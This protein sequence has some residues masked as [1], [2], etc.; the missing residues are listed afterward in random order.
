MVANQKM[1]NCEQVWQ[2]ISNYIDGDVDAA[3]RASMDEHFGTCKRCA[4]VLPF[5]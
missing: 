5:R 2:E 1:L 4:S 3:L